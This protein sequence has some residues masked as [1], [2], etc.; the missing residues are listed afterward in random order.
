PAFQGSRLDVQTA[1]RSDSA[2]AGRRKSRLRNGLIVGQIAMSLLLLSCA[3][4]FVR[5][6]G[7]GRAAD[8]GFKVDGI[9][10]AHI[11][12]ESAGYEDDRARTFFRAL[13][14]RMAT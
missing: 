6:L 1:L 10:T 12:V 14:D 13:T 8:P 3:G 9:V 5:A 7:R 11:D 4:L 2:G